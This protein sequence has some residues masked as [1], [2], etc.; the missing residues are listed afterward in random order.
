MDIIENSTTNPIG[1]QS[2]SKISGQL[3]S[4]FASIIVA[5]FPFVYFAN[6]NLNLLSQKDMWISAGLVIALWLILFLINVA[7]LRSVEKAS[8]ATII[9]VLPLSLYH[10]GLDAIQKVMR[11]F[12]Y[13]HG[14]VLFL[15]I[16]IISLLV[17]HWYFKVSLVRK[18]NLIIGAIF[19]ILALVNTVPSLVQSFR[20]ERARTAVESNLSNKVGDLISDTEH[21]PNIYLFILDEFSGQEGLERF[22]GYDNQKFYDDLEAL[23]FNVSKSSRSYT[24]LSK[25]EISNLL[26]LSLLA[27]S[28]SE[29]ERIEAMKSPYLLTTLKS[30]GYSF[31]L[32]N[33]QKYISTREGFFKYKFEPHGIFQQEE[34]LAKILIDKSVFFPI[35]IQPKLDRIETVKK[36]FDYGGRSS[37]FQES[38]LFTLGYF[39]FPH[40]PWVVNEFGE[41]LPESESKNWKN[42][43]TYLGQLK[44]AN[45]LV[46]EMVKTIIEDDPQSYIILVGDHGYRQAFHLEKLYG[47]KMDNPELETFYMRNILSAVYFGGEKLEIE[48]YSTINVLRTMM[49]KL[50]GLDLGL[51]EEAN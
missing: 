24:L 31:N 39:M 3:M 32:I 19:L 22:T 46:L 37:S 17:I 41:P 16:F 25:V 6:R 1:A 21:L 10:I 49:D 33:D 15:T 4:I 7:I 45:G 27:K 18:L 42:A 14:I 30:M 47:T 51:I 34:N 9:A 26:N 29:Q 20:A 43:N 50:F 36:M 8:L 28:F 12:H 44:Y 38:K 35:Q 5:L 48:G 13:W 2:K 23:S 40:H 11:N